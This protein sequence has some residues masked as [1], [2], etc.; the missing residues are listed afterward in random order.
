[1]K[2]PKTVGAVLAGVAVNVVLSTLTDVSMQA[3]G[4]FPPFGQVMG[5]AL[6][7]LARDPRLAAE[8][9]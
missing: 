1:M 4:V 7:A 2:A 3:A 5:D 6:F 8:D 9:R